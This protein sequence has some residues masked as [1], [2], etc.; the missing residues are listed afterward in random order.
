MLPGNLN[1]SRTFVRARAASSDGVEDEG[2]L[3]AALQQSRR[4][5]RR[6]G[7]PPAAY[8]GRTYHIHS[9]PCPSPAS[10]DRGPTKMPFARSPRPDS[11]YFCRAG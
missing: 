7:A 3:R 8:M 11:L 5:G 9:A 4:R 1:V 6:A 10:L 2:G